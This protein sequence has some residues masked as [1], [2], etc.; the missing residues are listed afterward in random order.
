[1]TCFEVGRENFLEM[2]KQTEYKGIM[3]FN[4]QSR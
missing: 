4:Q 2:E 1:M 3:H